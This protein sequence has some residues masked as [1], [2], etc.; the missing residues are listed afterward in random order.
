MG[1]M[2][3]DRSN[4]RGISARNML[5]R[6]M[7]QTEKEYLIP[8]RT[9]TAESANREPLPINVQT[10]HWIKINPMTEWRIEYPSAAK[11]APTQ[12]RIMTR[13]ISRKRFIVVAVA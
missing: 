6:E 9:P 11:M 13:T 5:D 7:I 12:N 4:D 8:F 1:T 3:S 2:K 10:R